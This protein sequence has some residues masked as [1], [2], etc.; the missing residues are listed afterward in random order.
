MCQPLQPHTGATLQFSHLRGSEV[1]THR[2]TSVKPHHDLRFVVV[3]SP[4][5]FIG[6][7]VE[8]SCHLLVFNLC[9]QTLEL[10][11][12]I[13]SQRSVGSAAGLFASPVRL[14]VSLCNQARELRCATR[15]PQCTVFFFSHHRFS[16]HRVQ[17]FPPA[18]LL[19]TLWSS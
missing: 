14:C 18:A 9:I 7:I 17:G 2:A 1:L 8:P 4:R 15:A 10:R 6:A 16:G 13:I 19:V 12:L 11:C 5:E 3:P